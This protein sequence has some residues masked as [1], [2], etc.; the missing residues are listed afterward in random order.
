MFKEQWSEIHDYVTSTWDLKENPVVNFRKA[1][2][3]STC[4]H[5]YHRKLK[6]MNINL[7]TYRS[8]HYIIETKPAKKTYFAEIQVRT[9]FE[10]GWSEID[11]TVR[12]LL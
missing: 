10:E 2:M 1:I 9:I 8:I 6:Q 7:G 5:M 3:Q 4:S 12:Y 11:H